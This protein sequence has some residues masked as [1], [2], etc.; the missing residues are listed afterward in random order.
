M[1]VNNNSAFPVPLQGS[2]SG[3]FGSS[4]SVSH[5]GSNFASSSYASFTSSFSAGALNGL[6][7]AYQNNP[8]NELLNTLGNLFNAISALQSYNGHCGCRPPP[9]PCPPQYP[10]QPPPLQ[11]GKMWDV[12]FDAKTGTKTAQW[13]P[14]VLD[15]NGNGKADITGGNIKGNG[16]L[17]GATVKGFDLNPEARQWEKKSVARRPGDGADALPAGT[18]AQVFDKSGKLLKTLSAQDLKSLQSSKSKW[19]GDGKDMGLG[20]QDGQRV[21]FRDANG[22]LVGELKQGK[23]DVASLAKNGDKTWQYHWGN[24]NE[25]EWTKAWD[26]K[27]GGDGMLVWD[28]DGDGKI[29]SGK[30]LFGHIDVNGK[31]TFKNGYE[32]LAHYFDK[33]RNGKVQGDELKGLKIWED[34]NG[35]GVTQQ[36]E[37]VALEK[38]QVRELN[39]RFN[40]AD[41]SSTFG[42]GPAQAPT[43]APA[44]APTPAPQQPAYHALMQQTFQLFQAI[45]VLRQLTSRFGML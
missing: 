28:A 5:H 19:G 7:S 40:E 20:L 43:P 4:T 21:D 38:H 9:P 16:K 30:E 39:T 44:P 35:D 27:T 32:K 36:G 26:S 2:F 17:E 42:H 1:N 33:D 41:M 15:L 6:N 18:T 45:D 22:K 25:N 24:K 34:R 37:L 8:F 3:S 29:T 13:S 31:N 14:I 11:Q 10:P 23:P 12:F